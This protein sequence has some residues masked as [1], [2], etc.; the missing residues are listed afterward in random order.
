MQNEIIAIR[1]YS[2]WSLQGKQH[3]NPTLVATDDTRSGNEVAPYIFYQSWEPHK[4]DNEEDK[5]SV[6]K[7]A[8]VHYGKILMITLS[9]RQ[10]LHSLKIYKELPICWN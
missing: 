8:I 4:A 2:I 5:L 10:W 1:N 6:E 9:T 7:K 3:T